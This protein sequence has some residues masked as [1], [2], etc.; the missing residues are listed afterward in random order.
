MFSQIIFAPLH[1]QRSNCI[2]AWWALTNGHHTEQKHHSAD[3]IKA[4]RDMKAAVKVCT[5]T[6][7]RSLLVSE[8]L[9]NAEL[10]LLLGFWD[11]AILRFTDYLI[12]ITDAN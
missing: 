2:L 7:R 6:W 4:G 9:D 8:E 5:N 12:F 11:C 1:W 3:G 10:E